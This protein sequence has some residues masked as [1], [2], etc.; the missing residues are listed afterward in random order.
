MIRK[1]ETNFSY[2]LERFISIRIYRKAIRDLPDLPDLPDLRQGKRALNKMFSS[3]RE[4][5]RAARAQKELLVARK[6][7]RDKFQIYAFERFLF[8]YFFQGELVY[9][10]MSPNWLDDNARFYIH[11]TTVT[12]AALRYTASGGVK[13]KLF[14]VRTRIPE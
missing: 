8:I 12:E 9:L 3:S 1:D 11:P 10:F 5:H 4:F 14:E 6:D 7:D 2:V 13:D